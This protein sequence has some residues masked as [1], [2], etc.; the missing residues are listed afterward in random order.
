MTSITVTLAGKPVTI[1]DIAP[2]RRELEQV[3]DRL[4][5]LYA[6]FDPARPERLLAREEEIRTLYNR[7]EELRFAVETWDAAHAG[8]ATILTIWEQ[9]RQLTGGAV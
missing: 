9:V 6:G 7:S 5:A 4:T 3:R 1:D 8:C 2:Y